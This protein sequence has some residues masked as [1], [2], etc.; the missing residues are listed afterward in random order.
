MGEEED[1]DG[2]ESKD[3]DR[4]GCNGADGAHRTDRGTDTGTDANTR[5]IFAAVPITGPHDTWQ[6]RCT[7]VALAPAK[8]F[9][10]QVTPSTGAAATLVQTAFHR[11]V[12]RSLPSSSEVSSV[13]ADEGVDI[14][15]AIQSVSVKIV[16]EDVT[17]GPSTNE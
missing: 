8:D 2:D 6:Q 14:F 9:K 3:C 10:V 12:Q 13:I 11:W 7:G 15:T 17:L 4:G 5:S 16:D 1:D